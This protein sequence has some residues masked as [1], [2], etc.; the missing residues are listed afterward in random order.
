MINKLY[1]IYFLLIFKIFQNE[2]LKIIENQ[3]IWEWRNYAD[4]F[5]E[6]QLLLIPFQYSSFSLQ[7]HAKRRNLIFQCIEL[8]K[9]WNEVLF[10][11]FCR[12]LIWGEICYCLMFWCV[13][14]YRDFFNV[15]VNIVVKSVWFSWGR[16]KR[17]CFTLKA[18]T[19]IVSLLDVCYY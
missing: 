3:N 17:C 8:Y 6:I 13:G 1:F 15:G 11:V 14:I 10:C 2:Y 18:L 12:G 19:V 16:A 5:Q 7:L 4:Q 9:W